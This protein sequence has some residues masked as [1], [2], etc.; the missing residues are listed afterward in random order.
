MGVLVESKKQRL[1][2]IADAPHTL[3]A[4]CPPGMVA[5]FFDM[6]KTL[7]PKPAG[8]FLNTL[9]MTACSCIALPFP[10]SSPGITF[11]V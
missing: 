10:L 11:S 5:V 7:L 6:D 9:S 8:D 3:L 4:S 2:H 1:F